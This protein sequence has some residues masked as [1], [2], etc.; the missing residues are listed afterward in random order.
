MIQEYWTIHF[1]SQIEGV[2]A[3]AKL[4]KLNGHKLEQFDIQTE[5]QQES[6]LTEITK[7]TNL[8]VTVHN[9]AKNQEL[10]GPPLHLQLRRYNKTE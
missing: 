2:E 5:K 3:S 6:A 7:N 4:S 9:V 8:S 10:D 1:R